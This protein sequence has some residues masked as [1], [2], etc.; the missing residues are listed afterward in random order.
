M[1]VGIGAGGFIGIALETVPG[2]YVPPTKYIP[3]LNESLKYKQ[4]TQWRRP[5][6]ATADM[7][8]G[9]AGNVNVEGDISMEALSDCVPYFLYCARTAPVKVGVGPYTYTFTPTALAIPS[10]TMSITII[11]NGMPMGYTGCVV[12]NFAFSI[13]SG[14]LKFD[15]TILGRD[16]AAVSLPTAAWGISTPFGAGSYDVQIP[17]ATS[18]FDT[19][20][21]E[22]KCDDGAVP[23]F[24]LRNTGRG[25]QFIRYGERAAELSVERDF[26]ARTEYDL[27]KAL[28][29]QTITIAASKGAGESIT[30][31]LPV[32]IKDTY[33]INGL[34]GQGDL[35]RAAVKYNMAQGATATYTITVV[36]PTE[37]IT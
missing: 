4:D 12:G 24:R 1:T 20:K 6:R 7:Q 10:R 23:E 14:L 34:S 17:T 28:T 37:N 32:A 11:R 21:F 26:E 16:E 13:D 33:E 2:T 31:L 22:F 5:I 18:V 8:G 29:A 36:T 25:A 30:F 35:L 3:I 15:C 27:F 9:V 19:D